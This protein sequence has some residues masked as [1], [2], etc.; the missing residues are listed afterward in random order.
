MAAVLADAEARVERLLAGLGLDGLPWGE[1]VRIGL[2]ANL[3]LAEND[4]ALAR[5]CLIEGQRAEE[6]VQRERQR[7]LDRLTRVVDRRS[8]A[9]P[10]YRSRASLRRRR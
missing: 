2:W 1:R 4:P 7:L 3:G 5:A 8:F 9:G 10:A 6:F